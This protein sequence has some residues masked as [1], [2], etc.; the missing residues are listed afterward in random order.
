M[1]EEHTKA[2][3]NYTILEIV[4]EAPEGTLY[5]AVE[6]STKNNVLLK[7]YYP[8]LEWSDEVL[9]DF[10]NL[11]SHLRYIEHP[12]LLPILDVDKHKN[13]P[14]IVF[15]SDPFTILSD[16]Q[17]LHTD[18]RITLDFF[19][20][21]A[22]AL[23]YLHKQEILH[24]SINADNIAVDSEGVPKLFD[25]GLSIVFKKLL[26]ENLEDGF[27]NLSISDIRCTAPEQI[28]GRNPTRA[29]DIYSFGIIFFFYV[30]GEYPILG[31]SASQTALAH[32]NMRT[33]NIEKVPPNVPEH[34]LAFIEKCIQ[35][36]PEERFISFAHIL[37]T[38]EQMENGKR[39][40]FD[41]EKR[42]VIKKTTPRYSRWLLAGIPALAILLF[43][44]F[45]FYA[46]RGVPTTTPAQ[47]EPSAVPSQQSTVPQATKPPTPEENIPPPTTGGSAEQQTKTTSGQVAFQEEKPQI[48]TEEI[49]SSN[50]RNIREFS[51]LGYGRFEDVAVSP[52]DRYFAFATSA[53]VLIYENTRFIKWVDV[54]TWATSVQFSRDNTILAVGTNLGDIQ[55]WDWENSEL[56]YTLSGHNKKVTKLLFATGDRQLYSAA[57]SS[58]IIAWNLASQA[59]FR[60]FDVLSNDLALSSDGRFL[61]T[62][63]GNKV[64]FLDI[65]SGA[66]HEFSFS[67][68]RIKAIALSPDDQYIAAGSESGYIQQWIIPGNFEI[69]DRD[70]YLGEVAVKDRIWNLQYIRGG[71]EFLV[72]VDDGRSVTHIIGRERPE[73]PF[74]LP[75]VSSN[76]TDAFGADFE[77]DSHSLGYEDRSVI[78]ITW[79]GRVAIGESV[80]IKPVFDSLNRLAFSKNGFILAAGGKKGTTNVWDLK[81]NHIL[82]Q[83]NNVLPP[84]NPISPDGSS[85]LVVPKGQ[86]IY[87][88]VSL[89]AETSPRNLSK[90][91]PGGSVS[92]AH[93]GKILVS[94]S[95][96]QPKIWDYTTG[97]DAFHS[98][99]TEKGCRITRSR[100]DG[101]LLQ[102]YSAAGVFLDWNKQAQN[103]CLKSSQNLQ[104]ISAFSADLGFFVFINLNGL[105]EGY[106][107]E[108]DLS[109]PYFKPENPVTALAV[110]PKGS[111]FVYGDHTGKLTFIDSRTGQ[112]VNR[113]IGNFGVVQ[114]IAFS[115]D[116]TKI[117]TTGSDGLIRLF[118]IVD[119][120]Q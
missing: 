90:F 37:G 24:G 65:N 86:E 49:K 35:F 54:Q 50:I 82:Y 47:I 110:S 45:Y 72:G 92:Y 113:I 52:N 73:P 99:T 3:G 83:E 100:N 7:T 62:S 9:N 111:M 42:F 55:M 85:I 60:P 101:E 16:R 14:Y 115:E 11:T 5:K 30:F 32:L 29:S 68:G 120:N 94:A 96:T 51:R 102:V 36:Q 87:Q 17:P 8:S 76:L 88:L 98:T 104:R 15:A 20:Q 67:R 78:S 97:N 84:G 25:H 66:K 22:D 89:N 53:G 48:P 38:L 39:P 59:V 63:S 93:D 75:Q 2:I 6:T 108:A 33:I 57:A 44:G 64:L 34:I 79:E 4:R 74:T 105:L 69:G 109:T 41:H 71:S 112:T 58:N 40:R 106:A 107:T 19:H 12:N 18:L 31:N 26:L 91:V 103:I 23:D 21:I 117:A 1:G 95:F 43:A 77:F 10:F 118:G 119:L 61:V 80:I 13:T 81:T 116:G 114:A 28:Q 70:K 27:E 46:L 56:L